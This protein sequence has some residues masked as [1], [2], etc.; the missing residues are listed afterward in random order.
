MNENGK[1]GWISEC[2]VCEG[3]SVCFHGGRLMRVLTGKASDADLSR[4][5]INDFYCGDGGTYF[6]VLYVELSLMAVDYFSNII[7]IL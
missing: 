3:A 6:Y 7:F 1:R 2:F 4:E 5:L